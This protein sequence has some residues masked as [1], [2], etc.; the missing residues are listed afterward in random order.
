MA[1]LSLSSRADVK[2][3]PGALCRR[4]AVASTTWAG[5]AVYI[6][7]SGSIAPAD[8]V[9]FAH[10]ISPGVAV[11]NNNGG[12]VF[13]AGDMIDVCVFGP[14]AGFTGAAEGS[15]AYPSASTVGVLEDAVASSGNYNYIVGQMHSST[16]LFINPFTSSFAQLTS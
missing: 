5:Q 4:F 3:L 16:I 7:S 9:T 1:A 11:A 13:A 8:A 2:P 12:T 15:F 10:A 6:N 14:L